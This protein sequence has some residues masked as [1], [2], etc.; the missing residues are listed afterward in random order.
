M[1]NTED[2]VTASKCPFAQSGLPNP[3]A[4]GK[5]SEGSEQNADVRDEGSAQIGEYKHDVAKPQPHEEAKGRCPWPFVFFHDPKTG[6]KDY[7]TWIVIG[8]VLCYTW[9]WFEKRMS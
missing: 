2:S 4:S 3:H 5:T 8:L 9:S 1:E 6:M 7:Q